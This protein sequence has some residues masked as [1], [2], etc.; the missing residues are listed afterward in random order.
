M[1]S[2]LNYHHRE[3]DQLWSSYQAKT[4]ENCFLPYEA[5]KDRRD[6]A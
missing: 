2:D 1:M 5:K 6:Q 3:M 4:F